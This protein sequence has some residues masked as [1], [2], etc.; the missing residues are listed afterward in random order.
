MRT[1]QEATKDII[2]SIARQKGSFAVTKSPTNAP[3]A[4]PFTLTAGS[5]RAVLVAGGYMVSL[6]LSREQL[7]M[8]RDECDALLRETDGDDKPPHAA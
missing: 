2:A 5:W 3:T 6:G 7:A 4:K 1:M 8:L